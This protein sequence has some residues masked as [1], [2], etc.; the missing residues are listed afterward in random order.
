MEEKKPLLEYSFIIER[1]KTFT[2]GGFRS[3]RIVVF[4][5]I[6]NLLAYQFCKDISIYFIP[7][8]IFVNYYLIKNFIFEALRL[9]FYDNNIEIIFPFFI[10]KVSYS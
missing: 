1:G 2:R 7:V 10:K 6:I 5:V 3:F 4:L 8:F 9:S